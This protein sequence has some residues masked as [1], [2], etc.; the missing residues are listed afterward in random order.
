[1]CNVRLSAE[2]WL[3]CGS[4]LCEPIM[5]NLT[6]QGQAAAALLGLGPALQAY[7]AVRGDDESQSTRTA[8][9]V[10]VQA[11][12]KVCEV[13]SELLPELVVQLLLVLQESGSRPPVLIV[14][15][16]ST[17]CVAAEV[18]VGPAQ[19]A[20]RLVAHMDQEAHLHQGHMDVNP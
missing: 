17:L 15:M 19:R 13:V 18:G 20:R 10:Q 3:S 11:M 1:M 6:E 16:A 4:A 12:L 8:T 2:L 7:R 9:A 14:S 5:L